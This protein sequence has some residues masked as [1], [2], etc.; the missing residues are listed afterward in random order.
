MRTTGF[1]LIAVSIILFLL[2][3]FSHVL[4]D[5]LGKVIC[6]KRY[7][8]P[9]SGVVGDMSCGFNMDMYLA[10]GL[11]LLC[12]TGIILAVVSNR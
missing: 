1:L 9:V 4:S 11:V 6:G 2:D 7:L 8:Q 12:L 3:R 10:V 5:S